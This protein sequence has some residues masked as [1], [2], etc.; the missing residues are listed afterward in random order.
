MT[1]LTMEPGHDGDLAIQCALLHDVIED[2][3]TTYDQVLATFGKSVADGVLALSKDKAV[4]KSQ[5]LADCLRRIRLQP[6][7]VGMVKLADRITNLQPPP[8]HWTPEKIKRYRAEAL[9]IHSALKDSSQVLA[10][11]LAHKIECYAAFEQ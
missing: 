8:A 3:D 1:A 7:E 5:R 10:T 2:T 11:R 6:P 9:E 4:E